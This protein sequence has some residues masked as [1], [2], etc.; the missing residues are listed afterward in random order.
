MRRRTFLLAL[1]GAGAALGGGGASFANAR[2]TLQLH[3]PLR[4]R[5]ADGTF[6][7]FDGFQLQSGSGTWG[8]DWSG[9][10]RVFDEDR[11]DL[12]TVGGLVRQPFRVR[13]AAAQPM[14]SVL[15]FGSTLV[16]D[17]I[18]DGF[19]GYRVTVCAGDISWDLRRGLRPMAHARGRGRRVGE[20]RLEHDNRILVS[21]DARPAL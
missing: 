17:V 14:G 15:Q 7:T 3:A 5:F 12:G 8:Y 19:Q 18:G 4:L 2:G 9:D 21:L 1:G 6:E 10:M 20:M 16:G 11:L 13:W